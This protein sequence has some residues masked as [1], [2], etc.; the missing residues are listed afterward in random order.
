MT[1]LI[2]SRFWD[3]FSARYEIAVMEWLV[4]KVL[5]LASVKAVFVTFT[6]QDE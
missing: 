2:H 3:A 6:D 5:H 1:L 4:K